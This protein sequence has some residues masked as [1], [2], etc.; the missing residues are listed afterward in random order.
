MNRLVGAKMLLE[1]SIEVA[2]E[3]MKRLNQ[4][5]NSVQLCMCLVMKVKPD[6]IKNNIGMLGP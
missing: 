1:K 3:A 2:P 5:R 6:V 4:S